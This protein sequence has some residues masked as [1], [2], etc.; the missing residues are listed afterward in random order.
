[1]PQARVSKRALAVVV[2]LALASAGALASVTLG[3]SSAPADTTSTTSPTSTAN[4]T[5]P[6]TPTAAAATTTPTATKPTEPRKTAKT[7]YALL[8][9]EGF[10]CKR[11][12]CRYIPFAHALATVLR[13]NRVVARAK[14]NAQGRANVLVKSMPGQYAVAATGTL[15]G[16]PLHLR[17]HAPRPI[18][19]L[20]LPFSVNIC[21]P[22][23]FC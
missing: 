3:A 12:A 17:V 7:G 18:A 14:L 5:S 9:H 19:G 15:N 4:P 20:M 13:N 21:P 16:R 11:R 2:A 8:I 22:G 10:V 23:A 1:M 6:A